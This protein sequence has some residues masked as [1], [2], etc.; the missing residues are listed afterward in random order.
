MDADERGSEE[1]DNGVAEPK[2]EDAPKI[3]LY[4]VAVSA[5]ICGSLLPGKRQG[6]DRK[7][8]V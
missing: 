6:R 3:H 8:N 5:F 7:F 2:Q 1:A 4:C